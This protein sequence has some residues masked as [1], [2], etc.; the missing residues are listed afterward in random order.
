MLTY[1]KCKQNLELLSVLLEDILYSDIS[2]SVSVKWVP[3]PGMSEVSG[4]SVCPRR[5]AVCFRASA[6]QHSP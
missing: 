1:Y 6:V 3:L 5:L 4:R 2:S